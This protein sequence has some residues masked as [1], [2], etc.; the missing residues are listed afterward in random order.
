[1]KQDRNESNG[2]S[3]DTPEFPAGHV[4]SI[5]KK[6]TFSL[7]ASIALVA[8]FGLAMTYFLL[9]WKGE[10]ELSRLGDEQLSFLTGSVK[11]PLWNFDQDSI[12]VIARTFAQNAV[13]EHVSVQD[14]Q[15][16]VL[17]KFERER[18]QLGHID[19]K[20][21]IYY[22]G[23]L[24]G[25]VDLRLT[26]SLYLKALREML[27]WSGMGVFS[28][29]LV[30]ILL[31]RLLI[32][33]YLR[34]PLQGLSAIAQSYGTGEYETTGGRM[35][36]EEFQEFERVL[37]RMGQEIK[38]QV[39]QIRDAEK[40]YRHIFENAMEGIF[41]FSGDGGRLLSINP[42]LARMLAYDSPEEMMS[43][44]NSRA[45]DFYADSR[46]REDLLNRLRKD[47]YAND[48]EVQ[49]VRRDKQ[50]IW[51]SFDARAVFDQNGELQLVEGFIRDITQRKQVEAEKKQLESQLRHSQKMEAIGTLSGGVAHEFN[52]MLGII[53]G[54]VELALD[55]IPKDNP[56]SD[57]LSEIRKA[58][59]RG[60][61]IVQQLLRFSRQKDQPLKA[62]DLGP[63]I[64]EALGFLRVSIPT[65]IEFEVK[66]PEQCW[67]IVGD[68]TQI[69]QV[70][71]NLCTNSAHAMEGEGGTLTVSLENIAF[72]TSEV[73]F[74]QELPPGRYVALKIS[75]T[76]CGI[77]PGCL[78]RI[79]EPFFST[80]DVGQ[81]TG[82][83]MAVVHG[84]MKGHHGG[85]RVSSQE[86]VGTTVE[87]CFPSNSE[88]VAATLELAPSVKGGN[89]SILCVDDEE[90][91]GRITQKQLE[92]LGYRVE[93]ETQPLEA[94]EMIEKDPQR[95]DLVITDLIMPKLRGDRLLMRLKTINP[96]IK[97]ILCS[98]FSEGIDTEKALQLQA[99]A[100]L[101]KPVS[102]DELGQVVRRILDEK[103][104]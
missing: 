55:D 23:V 59:L 49:L 78:D 42:A 6:L 48:F 44:E 76:G 80:K 73:F 65:V 39:M 17:V 81:G 47:G 41:Q 12:A 102:R 103:K 94:L 104:E 64:K 93:M 38:L 5:S 98:G 22:E 97:M 77:D 32:K 89:E 54:N 79:F 72:E 16:R 99:D 87:C 85:V 43:Q 56:A 69:H 10:K 58:S 25:S 7:V 91:I 11:V 60:T 3:S 51:V 18:G 86:G 67:P 95:F 62:L 63:L 92:R 4:P 34:R 30:L 29:L 33:G 57:F 26:K 88:G 13:V 101:R 83:G 28:L 61:E 75:D 66:M 27:L 24:I 31:T 74:D 1:M 37:G 100:F 68:P 2:V 36:Y 8:F 20:G 71:I 35:P 96:R 14:G 50:I 52:N 53:L 90:S 84:I 46:R 15:G 82:M 40:R 21:D 45:M 9:T 70:M 19:K